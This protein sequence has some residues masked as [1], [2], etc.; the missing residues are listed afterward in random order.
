MTVSVN[1]NAWGRE[2]VGEKNFVPEGGCSDYVGFIY[3]DSLR[4]VACALH[5]INYIY[6]WS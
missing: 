5:G 2:G 3:F 6:F 4:V 1:L